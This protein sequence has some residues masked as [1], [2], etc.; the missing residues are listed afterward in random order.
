MATTPE[1]WKSFLRALDES[2][3]QPI[4]IHCFGG[5]VITLL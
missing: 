2:L 5:F 1:L 4:Q 3:E